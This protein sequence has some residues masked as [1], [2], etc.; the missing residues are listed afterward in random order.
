MMLRWL[1]GSAGFLALSGCINPES[2]FIDGRTLNLCN[3]TIPVCETMANCVLDETN[4]TQG[5][6]DEGATQRLIVHT[7]AA[8]TITVELYFV[9]EVSPG[10][11]TEVTY[12]EV[13]CQSSDDETSGGADI[14]QQ[15]G[16]ARIWTNSHQVV[17]AGD[18][19]VEVFSDAQAQ[20]LLLVDVQ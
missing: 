19:L 10:I 11:D 7:D 9:T 13:D 20:Y 3:S 6:F 1:C 5:N 12:N 4:Y 8:A 18:H 14:F 15:A 17:T 16:P 2:N